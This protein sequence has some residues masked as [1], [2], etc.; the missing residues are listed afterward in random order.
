VFVL[1]RKQ[2]NAE[3]PYRAFGYP[4]VPVLYILAAAAILM[5]LLFYKTSTSWPGLVIVLTGI[6]VYWIWRRRGIPQAEGR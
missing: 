6:P 5:V 4:V 1:R 2:P 3:R